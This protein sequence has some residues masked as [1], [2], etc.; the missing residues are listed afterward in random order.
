[1]TSDLIIFGAIG[2]VAQLVDG[3]L[4]MAFGV[5]ASSSLLAFGAPPAIVS[6]AVHAA[7]IATTGVSGL[8][9]VWQRNVNWRLLLRLAVAGMLGGAFGAYLLAEVLPERFVRPLVAAYLFAMAV[10]IFARVLGRAP[11]PPKVPAA[12]LGLAGGCLDAIG[13][14]GWGPLVASTLIATGDEPRRSIGTVN[15]AEFFVSF[16]VSIAFLATLDLAGYGAVVLGL[17][18]GGILA[19]PLA[20]WLVRVMLPRLAMALVA[21]IVLGLSLYNFVR[22]VI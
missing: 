6:A 8:S 14:G 2:F 11:A 20:G 19:A 21:T 4:G 3:A 16:A 13:G 7:E 12:P 18:A 9:H 17:V 22:L 5:L 10:L 15:T 1:M